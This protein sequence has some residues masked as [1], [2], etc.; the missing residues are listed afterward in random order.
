MPYQVIIKKQPRGLCHRGIAG[1]APW[2]EIGG[3]LIMLFCWRR[4]GFPS[5][6]FLGNLTIP[7][8]PEHLSF[9]ASNHTTSD[10]MYMQP[11]EHNQEGAR[12]R[13]RPSLHRGTGDIATP[14]PLIPDKPGVCALNMK[15]AHNLTPVTPLRWPSFGPSRSRWSECRACPDTDTPWGLGSTASCCCILY[16][17]RALLNALLNACQD[18]RC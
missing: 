10:L 6:C 3:L 4:S 9:P 7:A 5:P 16:T 8:V 13:P 12:V 2:K 15:R 14:G 11:G 1:I 17:I 18:W